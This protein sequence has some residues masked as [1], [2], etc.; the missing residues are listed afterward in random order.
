LCRL[1]SLDEDGE[2][3]GIAADYLALISE[4][5]GLKFEVINGLAWPEVYDMAIK[6]DIDVLSCY[7]QNKR[8]RRTLPLFRTLLLL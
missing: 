6:G 3:K 5:T 8:K 2:Y 4:K 1:S 7:W